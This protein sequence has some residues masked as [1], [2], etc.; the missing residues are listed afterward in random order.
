MVAFLG[1]YY[2]IANFKSKGKPSSVI[3]KDMSA[4]YD[5]NSASNG[6]WLPSPYALS[7]SNQWP[8]AEGL[9][10]LHK[11]KGE[12]VALETEEFKF[13][14]A[15]CAIEKQDKQFHMRHAEYSAK[16]REIL[17]A[18]GAKIKLLASKC[19][20][21]QGDK[22]DKK[23]NPPGALASRLDTLSAK[24][25]G[26]VMM[27]TGWRNPLFTDELSIKYMEDYKR[28]EGKAKE[29]QDHVDWC[30]DFYAG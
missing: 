7:M 24:L 9:K 2:V 1:D 21:A 8:A 22:E 6:E 5:V 15:V 27:P 12:D 26:L 30:E 19:P 11:R 23:F 18:L 3:K 16:V 29:S 13:A 4:G 25:R 14:Y 17:D 10:A 28:Q 20:I